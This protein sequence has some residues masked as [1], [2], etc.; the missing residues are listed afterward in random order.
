LRTLILLFLLVAPPLVGAPLSPAQLRELLDAPEPPILVD[1]R[2]AGERRARPLPGS[3]APAPG[4][5]LAGT[6]GGRVVLIH[7]PAE[8]PDL[9]TRQAWLEQGF[10]VYLFPGATEQLQALG[11]VAASVEPEPRGEIKFVIPRGIC[12]SLPPVREEWR[13]R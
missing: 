2:Q 5:T 6:G 10:E 1:L 11:L 12:E 9:A 7:P 4:A 13:A 3:I 8:A